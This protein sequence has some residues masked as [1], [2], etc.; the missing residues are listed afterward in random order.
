MEA[1]PQGRV[2]G[3]KR[4]SSGKDVPMG[5]KNRGR[6]ILLSY[7][8]HLSRGEREKKECGYMEGSPL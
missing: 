5:G 2:V 1:R 3:I 8:I 6:E 4:V 7:L